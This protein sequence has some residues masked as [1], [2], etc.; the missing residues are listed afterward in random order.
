[1]PVHVFEPLR[2]QQIIY[3]TLN[4]VNKSAYDDLN[5]ILFEV[6]EIKGDKFL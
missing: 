5:V 1:M 6:Y 3:E 2:Q 4:G